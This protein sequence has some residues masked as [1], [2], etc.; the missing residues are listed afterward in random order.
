MKDRDECPGRKGFL[1]GEK[2]SG[3]NGSSQSGGGVGGWGGARDSEMRGCVEWS[4]DTNDLEKQRGTR[5]GVRGP[6]C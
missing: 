3:D 4:V 1:P 5:E 2:T 6:K